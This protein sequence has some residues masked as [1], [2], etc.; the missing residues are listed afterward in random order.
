MLRTMSVVNGLFWVA[1]K[2][3]NV[4]QDTRKGVEFHVKFAT[5]VTAPILR[6]V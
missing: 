5:A 4:E 2:T 1:T 3:A 6:K